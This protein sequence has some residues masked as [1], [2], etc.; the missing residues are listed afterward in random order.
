MQDKIKIVPNCKRSQ[1]ILGISFGVIFSLILIVFFIA[2]A[3]IVIK[4]FLTL[5]NCTELGIFVDNFKADVQKSW[6]SPIDSHVFPGNLPSSIEYVCFADFSR[7]L[8]GKNSD[9]GNELSLF[10]GKNAQLFFYPSSK[11]CDMPYHPI[12]HLNMDVILLKDN[13]YC[14]PVTD[15][16][17]KILIKKDSGEALVTVE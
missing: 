9:I 15:G 1:Q 14:I 5:Q 17:V 8:K 13:P 6:S 12:A 16:S 4:H 11:A 7:S 10:E 2:I 3:F